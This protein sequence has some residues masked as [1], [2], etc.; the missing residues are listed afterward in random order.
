MNPTQFKT[1]IRMN[2]I[3]VGRVLVRYKIEVSDAQTVEHST[4]LKS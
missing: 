3:P 4:Q 2:P 1:S